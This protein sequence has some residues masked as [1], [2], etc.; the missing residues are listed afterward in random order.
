MFVLMKSL[1]NGFK[2]GSCGPKTRSLGQNLIKPSV[3]A[4]GHSFSLI[5][6]KLCQNVFLDEI[7]DKLKNGSCW[8]ENYVTRSNLRKTLCT[9]SRPHFQSDYQETW[10]E[11]LS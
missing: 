2:N 6:M 1:K 3:H 8:V 11:Y 9:L 5:I 4:R 7:L 10:S